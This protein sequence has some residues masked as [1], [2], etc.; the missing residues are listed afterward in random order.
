MAAT[1]VQMKLAVFIN[2]LKRCLL[3]HLSTAPSN[4]FSPGKESQNIQKS[5]LDFSVECLKCVNKNL[6]LR[7]IQKKES[8]G[9]PF[10]IVQKQVRVFFF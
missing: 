8:V 2:V 1:I 6:I 3:F 4:H 10:K 7:H 5:H 9:V